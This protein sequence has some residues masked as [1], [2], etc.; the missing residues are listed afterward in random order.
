MKRSSNERIPG[1][2]IFWFFGFFFE[3]FFWVRFSVCV[4][5]HLCMMI[6]FACSLPIF[7][8]LIVFFLRFMSFRLFTFRVVVKLKMCNFLDHLWS[9]LLGEVHRHSTP[10]ACR[11]SIHPSTHSLIY[12]SVH[13]SFIRPSAHPPGHPF[14]HPCFLLKVVSLQHQ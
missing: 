4:S 11:A 2:L 7:C 12:P 1:F 8:L 14:I 3:F 5:K 9:H 13:L 6:V 10:P